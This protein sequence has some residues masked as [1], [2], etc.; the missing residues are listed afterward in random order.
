MNI[1]ASLNTSNLI[2]VIQRVH[3]ARP[4]N[5]NSLAF[6]VTGIYSLDGYLVLYL[7]L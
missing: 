3:A 6:F 7:S 4:V 2:S 5:S 1:I